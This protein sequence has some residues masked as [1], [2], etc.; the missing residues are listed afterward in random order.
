MGKRVNI[1]ASCVRLE[2]A[3]EAFAAPRDAGVLLIGKSG[4][5][6][7]DLA[8]RLL[9]RGARLVCDDRTE[10]SV[11]RGRLIARAPARLAGLIELRG[12][13]I[14]EMSSVASAPVCLVVNLSDKVKRLPARQSYSP[15][16]PLVLAKANQPALIALNAFDVSAPDKIIAAVAALRHHRLRDTVKRN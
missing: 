9:G 3:A 12:V 16:K 10:L 5:G 1:H 13:G 6:K 14:I 4:A 15:L 8:L 11:E 2:D 7:S